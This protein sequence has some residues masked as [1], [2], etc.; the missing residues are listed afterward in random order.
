MT[1]DDKLAEVFDRGLADGVDTLSPADRELFRIQ[2]F[3]IEYEMN[4]LSGYFYNRLPNVGEI[5][6]AVE[7]MRKHTPALAALLNDAAQLFIE[8]TD[9]DP[10]T[11]W[12]NVLKRY[13]PT[14]RFSDVHDRIAALNSYGLGGESIAEIG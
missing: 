11:T 8:Y 7:A 14:D 3:I 10:Q 6:A 9:P 4:G 1:T 2:D 13:D 12:S 5:A